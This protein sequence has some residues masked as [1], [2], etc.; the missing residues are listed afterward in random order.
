MKAVII[1]LII[2]AAIIAVTIALTRIEFG[3]PLH[4]SLPCL[5]KQKPSLE[6]VAR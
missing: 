5:D 3:Q 6:V 2:W 4:S 1:A